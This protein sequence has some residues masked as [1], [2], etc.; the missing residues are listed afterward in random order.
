MV[1]V[2]SI[3][4]TDKNPEFKILGSLALVNMSNERN[5]RWQIRGHQSKLLLDLENGSL[6]ILWDFESGRYAAIF[7]HVRYARYVSVSDFFNSMAVDSDRLRLRSPLRTILSQGSRKM[8]LAYGLF[9]LSALWCHPTV[10]CNFPILKTPPRKRCSL[11]HSET[12][13]SLETPNISSTPP[14][15]SG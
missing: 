7:R 5:S 8:H 6:G 12:H 9:P 1:K 4:P 3:S 2:Y 15:C 13:K 14:V 10:V 11:I